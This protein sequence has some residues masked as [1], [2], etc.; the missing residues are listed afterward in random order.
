[1][2]LPQDFIDYT[3][4]LFGDELFSRYLSAFDE[5]APVSIRINPFKLHDGIN[6]NACSL[7][8][9][10]VPWCKYGYYLTER[11]DFTFDP[12]FHAGVYYVQEASSMFLAQAIK[13]Y[14][15]EDVQM[16]DLCAAPGG[17]STVARSFITP[18]SLLICN[19]PIHNRANILT[20]NIIKFGA[21]N[22]FVTNN[23]PRD[24]KKNK[25]CF[26][27]VL[28]DVP[29]SGEGMFRK[30]ERAI[31]EWSRLNVRICCMLQREIISDIWD[32]LVPGGLLIYSTCTFNTLE[33]EENVK[34][35]CEKFGA[36][37]LPIATQ[38]SWNITGSLLKGFNGPVYRFIPG[39]TKGEGL[40][41]SVMRKNGDD[42]KVQNY[43]LKS[44]TSK[45]TTSN[46]HFMTAECP[47]NSTSNISDALA[48]DIDLGKYTT[49]D[50]DYNQAIQYLRR[51]AIKLTADTP[52]GIVLI[53]YKHFPLGFAKNIGNRA[54]NL[55]PKEWA[56]RTTH[57]PTTPILPL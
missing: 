37:L 56:I 31:K 22:T 39:L 10:P 12:L 47:N 23:Y 19:E 27:V 38:P 46:L 45:L 41:F 21:K 29:C 8:D 36:E 25:L 9:K 48:A 14:I 52:K 6:K 49:V 34:W 30:D 26:D 44:L 24:F 32:C 55:Y 54:N 50:V 20:E 53:T 5:P 15:R 35:I 28:A 13:Q 1:M 17:K 40:F 7:I 2:N 57:I 18:D 43:C 3:R 51:E 16:L 33:N 11:P 4:S 42:D